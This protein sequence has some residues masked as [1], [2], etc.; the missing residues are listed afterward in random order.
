MDDLAKRTWRRIGEEVTG[1]SG[2][3]GQAAAASASFLLGELSEKEY[4]A[5]A[6]TLGASFENDMHFVLG[7]AASQIGEDARAR[8]HYMRS[9]EAS[10]GR[11]FPWYLASEEVDGDG[12]AR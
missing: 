12:L 11:E 4:R 8:I 7:F 6:A 9:M 10:V 2:R 3:S 1:L 5:E